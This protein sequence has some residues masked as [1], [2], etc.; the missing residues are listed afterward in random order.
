ML[1]GFPFLDAVVRILN[2]RHSIVKARLDLEPALLLSAL[3]V[4]P[5][6]AM[7]DRAPLPE[8]D[9]LLPDVLASVVA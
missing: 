5:A 6:V 7:L 2:M 3:F 1:V 9:C 8:T 4:P